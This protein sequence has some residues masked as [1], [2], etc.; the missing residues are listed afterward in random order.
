MKKKLLSVL[1]VLVIMVT[2][3][4][5]AYA[6]WNGW[7]S[8]MVGEHVYYYVGTVEY[9][10]QVSTSGMPAGLTLAEE[11]DTYGRDLYLSGYPMYK[12]DYM[13]WISATDGHSYSCEVVVDSTEP[14]GPV[15]APPY[16]SWTSKN[17]R[18]SQNESVYVSVGVV[19]DGGWDLYYTWYKNGNQMYGA[20]AASF[21]C[22]TSSVRKDVYQCKI[23]AYKG[24]GNVTLWSNEVWVEVV[25]TY[26]SAVKLYSMPYKLDYFE[27]EYL[28]T[29]GLG[30]TVTYNNGY[31][32]K[33]YKG[34]SCSPTT[35]S[36]TGTQKI[37]VS[38][39][40]CSTSFNVNVKPSVK[41]DSISLDSPPDKV[42]YFIGENLDPKGL[43]V[44]CKYS[45]GGQEYIYSG[46][47]CSPN[48]FTKAGTETVT[49]TYGGKTCTFTVEVND[50]YTSV[51]MGVVTPPAKTEYEVGDTLDLTGLTLYV[52][53]MGGDREIIDSDNENITIEP[54]TLNVPGQQ[55][56]T[57]TLL[58]ASHLTCDFTVNVKAKDEPA[59]VIV[60]PETTETE[61]PAETAAPEETPEKSE[62]GINPVM[63]IVIGVLAVIVVVL[64]TSL[65]VM[66]NR[67][68]KRQEE[69]LRK[70][71]KEDYTGKH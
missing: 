9:G 15:T 58:E 22:D 5:A 31:Q 54:R 26:V 45:N 42:N 63:W 29:D 20:D 47:S 6:G 40:G 14:V 2:L 59:P 30:L 19:N 65:I 55:K 49:V 41:V 8:C 37:T 66:Q 32:E 67:M 71:E 70:E 25:G 4:P 56:V 44:L 28:N 61:A 48:V 24:N 52:D 51:G 11:G 13:V 39:G 46:L 43:G 10:A 36:K 53:Y 34:F 68:K 21:Y 7:V 33:I 1:M 62:S 16:V 12:G 64:L 60:I 17:V 69:L 50:A 57:V 38:Y 18:C 23:D 35:L 3:I 27:N